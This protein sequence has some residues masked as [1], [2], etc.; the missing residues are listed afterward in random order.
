[1]DRIRQGRDY[2]PFHTSSRKIGTDS[3][4]NIN[5]NIGVCPLGPVMKQV[6]QYPDEF[7]KIIS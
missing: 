6:M 4:I 1:M 5:V 3:N 7:S 2:L